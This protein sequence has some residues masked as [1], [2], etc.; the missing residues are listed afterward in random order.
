MRPKHLS[1]VSPSGGART[2]EPRT[3]AERIAADPHYYDDRDL[4]ADLASEHGMS[5]T[6]D[7]TRASVYSLA[8]Q[9]GHSAGIEEI[10]REY[11]DLAAL[12][13]TAEEEGAH[14]EQARQEPEILALREV[15]AALPKCEHRGCKVVATR[16][17]A[18]APGYT[19]ACD[20]D[21][22][23]VVQPQYHPVEDLP[24]AKAVRRLRDLYAGEGVSR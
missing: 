9:R 4:E 18:N 19:L 11:T 13:R 16:R 14:T 17:Y 22:H 7:V 12:A 5:E 2:A 24:V 15:L 23:L 20:D 6:S 1:L 10:A 8:Y 21:A 3:V